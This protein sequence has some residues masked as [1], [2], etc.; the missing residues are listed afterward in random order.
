MHERLVRRLKV[1]DR[2]AD[3]KVGLTRRR[4]L[5]GLTRTRVRRLSGF[6]R[7]GACEAPIRLTIGLTI[8]LT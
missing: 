2:W 8:G 1:S 4:V 6:T 3:S 5:A 7:R